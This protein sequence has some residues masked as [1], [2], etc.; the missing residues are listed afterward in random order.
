MMSKLVA[1]TKSTLDD[2]ILAEIKGPVE[3][4]FFLFVFYAAIHLIGFFASTVKIVEQ[5]TSVA[6]T[7]IAAYLGLKIVKAVSHWYYEEGHKTSHLKIDVALMP[8]LQ[9]LAELIIGLIALGLVFGEFGYDITAILALSS[10]VGLVAGLASQETLGNVFAGLALQLDRALHYGD[11][12]RLPSG[13]LA[14]LKKIGMR[15][16]KLVDVSGNAIIISNSEFAK[17]RVTKIG[18]AGAKADAVVSFEAPIGLSVEELAASLE[19]A[20]K[21]EKPAWRCEGKIAGST[22][23]TKAPGWYEGTIGVP[24]NDMAAVGDAT[25]FTNGRIAELIKKHLAKKR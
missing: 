22:G 7:L 20:I 3:S 9:K 16:T 14:R 21:K 19:T 11:Y 23:K 15:S 4:F 12:I 8:L 10:V 24:I 18:A 25:D 13:E 2:R 6:V 1:K 17:L 5:Y